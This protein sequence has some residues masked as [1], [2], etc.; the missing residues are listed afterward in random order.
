MPHAPGAEQRHD[1]AA[2]HLEHDMAGKDVAEQSERVA[3][4]RERNEITSI[5]VDQRQH[6]HRHARGHEELQEL[7][8]V[9]A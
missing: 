9:L 5:G 6:V 2:E 1:H 3:D 8:P 4:G 7:E